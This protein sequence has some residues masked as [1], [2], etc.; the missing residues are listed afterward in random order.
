VKETIVTHPKRAGA[1]TRLDDRRTF[2][3]RSLSTA[4]L[5]GFA[6]ASTD[7][8]AAA[9]M[10]ATMGG[11]SS[12][13]RILDMRIA[14]SKVALSRNFDETVQLFERE[15]QLWPRE[16]SVDLISRQAPWSAV[17]AEV[18]RL[19][20]R[21]GLMIFS[22]IDTGRLTSLS[23]RHKSSALYL[24]GNPV[25]A[26][27]ILNIDPR[28]SFYVPFRVALYAEGGAGRASLCYDRPSS[29][30]AALDARLTAIGLELDSK[31]D[32]VA[33]ALQQAS[34]SG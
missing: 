10:E 24:V 8:E 14:Q 25:I 34:A 31:I 16:T 21:R 2:L 19:G 1:G 33:D 32:A 11:M 29:F 23:G 28:G 7:S 12:G 3:T 5:W 27:E 17:Q 4:A 30:L 22:K 9:R 18:A 26:N 6:L 20:G 13:S 15:L